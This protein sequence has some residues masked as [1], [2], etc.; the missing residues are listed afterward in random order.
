MVRWK[1]K[2]L[3]GRKP[4]RCVSLNMLFRIRCMVLWILANTQI[5]KKKFET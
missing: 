4:T 3:F 1:K 2:G 5:K